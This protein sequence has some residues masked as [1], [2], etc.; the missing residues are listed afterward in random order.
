M[1]K[2][3][4]DTNKVKTLIRISEQYNANDF[5]KTFDFANQAL[6][7]SEELKW[8]KGTALAYFYLGSASYNQGNFTAALNYRLKELAV[9]QK[10]K[11]GKNVC[12]TLGNIGVCYGDLGNNVKAIEY[13]IFSL[14]MSEKLNLTDQAINSLTNIATSYEGQN[15]LDK[16]LEYYFKSLKLAEQYKYDENIAINLGNIGNVYSAQANYSKALEYYLKALQVNE[17]IDN[18]NLLSS[19]YANI[20]AV[21]QFQGDSASNKGN[22]VLLEQ[23]SNQALVYYFKA[24]KYTELVGNEYFQAYALGNIGAIYITLKNYKAAEEY[25]QKSL[26]IAIKINSTEIIT[27]AHHRFYD[28]YKKTNMSDKALQH[29]EKYIAL[30]DS[31]STTDNRKAISELQI[32]F[33]SEKKEAENKTLAQANKLQTLEINNNRYLMAGLLGL[34]CLALCLSFL[35]IRQN[36]LKARQLV[37]Q[38][39]QKLLRTQ[40]NPHFIFNSLASIESFIYDHQPK[41][42][43]IY[44]SNFS[45]LMR[46]I[47]ENSALDYITLEKEIEFLN[48]YLSLQ[49]LRLD[50]N[51]SYTIEV[52]KNIDPEQIYLPPMLTQPFIE[53]A[54]EHGF[55]G[56]EKPGDIKVLFNLVSTNLQVQIIDNGIGI[57][58]AQQQK[59]SHKK[60]KSMATQITME[61]LA[62]LNKSKKKKLSFTYTDM[63]D[64]QTGLSGTKIVFLI[65]LQ[66]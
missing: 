4:D 60:Y 24:L 11:I 50:D 28:L 48:Y 29:H 25:L 3:H 14:E 64:A 34:L 54:I 1:Q 30:R 19:V 17:R 47:L 57:D 5:K 6:K 51:L 36:K 42:A 41:E 27:D 26:D 18:K 49:K 23:K 2:Q 55:R 44:L 62:F 61:R 58:K 16:A 7:L 66:N 43:G 53:N 35:I 46:L 59:D 38:F 39:E 45:R 15:N 40:M 21:Y 56:S 9:W 12:K 32:K 65:P 22:T 63:A 52:D 10:L 8:L 20:G 31:A 37:V 13:Y 33:E